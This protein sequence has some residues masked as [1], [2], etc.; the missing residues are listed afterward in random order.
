MPINQFVTPRIPTHQEIQRG[1]A[2]GRRERSRAVSAMA[3]SLVD[4]LI[5]RKV[6]HITGGGRIAPLAG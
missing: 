3:R 2:Q 4:F 1:I 6:K 5:G